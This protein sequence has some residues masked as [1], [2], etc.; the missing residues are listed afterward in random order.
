ME[1][2]SQEHWS[3]LPCPS[4]GDCPDPGIEPRSPAPQADSSLTESPGNQTPMKTIKYELYV[5]ILK[6]ANDVQIYFSRKSV[7]LPWYI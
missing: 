5:K 3:G 4:P 7:P 1:F 6:M 2:S